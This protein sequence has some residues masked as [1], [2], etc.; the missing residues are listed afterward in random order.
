M[1]MKNQSLLRR[2][3]FGFSAAALLCM[4]VHSA[5]AATTWDANADFSLASNPNGAWTYQW[6]TGLAPGQY[7][8]M[9]TAEANFGGQP[10]LQSW[11]LGGSSVPAVLK[12]TDLVNTYYGWA[13]GVLGM[14]PGSGGNHA[15]V[16]WTVPISGAYSFVSSFTWVGGAGQGDGVIPS[17]SKNVFGAFQSFGSQHI[18]N[19]SSYGNTWSW[20]DTLNLNA[21]DT[22]S[23]AINPNAGGNGADSTVLSA[24]I[25]AVP[26]PSTSALV[27]GALV[28]GSVLRRNRRQRASL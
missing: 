8:N 19:T 26:E 15:V 1:K 18:G 27:A 3:A 6:L 2:P 4:T 21:G 22:I 12:N 13:P 28:C 16:T 17:V 5:M 7:G 10:G 20:N 11:D 23:W 25:T 14:H 9:T 24:V